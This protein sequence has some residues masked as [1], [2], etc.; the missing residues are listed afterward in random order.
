MLSGNQIKAA[1][2]LAGAGQAEIA[3]AAGITRQSLSR[4]EGSGPQPVVSRDATVA[5]VL[6]ALG[7]RGVMFQTE[8]LLWSREGLNKSQLELLDLEIYQLFQLW[9]LAT[10][11]EFRMLERYR[12]L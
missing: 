8:A 6:A 9:R 10:A 2:I 4:L 12:E 5:A 11:A 3:A 7:A 1:R